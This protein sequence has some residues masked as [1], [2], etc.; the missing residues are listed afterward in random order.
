MLIANNIIIIITVEP[1]HNGHPG[2]ELSGRCREV[3][4]RVKCIAWFAC[5]MQ[6]QVQMQAM[7]RVNIE[8]A[9]ANARK[10]ENLHYV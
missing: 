9:N 3:S 6:M 4:I 5:A 1:L 8:N 7:E 2:A 10:K